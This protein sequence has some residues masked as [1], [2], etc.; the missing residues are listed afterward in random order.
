MSRKQDNELKRRFEHK[1]YLAKE[2]P[3]NL[4]D[5][6]D[7][8]LKEI[9]SGTFSLAKVL[10][11]THLLLQN[12]A[13]R[14]LD[15]GGNL[16]DL[17]HLQVLDL[18]SNL[19]QRL[20]DK[21]HNF[22]S[23]QI[24][25]LSKNRLQSL[26]PSFVK[27]SSL[28][29]L[30]LE[31]NALKFVPSEIGALTQLVVLGLAGNPFSEL[32]DQIL[33][34]ANLQELTLP[35]ERMR[36]P[37]AD[38]C[39]DGV[40]AILRFIEGT[41]TGYNTSTSISES[42][43]HVSHHGPQETGCAQASPDASFEQKPQ[44]Q[45]L[46]AVELER[47]LQ[48]DQKGQMQ[49]A[50][51]ANQSRQKVLGQL[52]EDEARLH[53]ELTA[54]QRKRDQD[55][56]KLVH[57]LLSAE[58][59]ADRLIQQLL[60]RNE[61]A[62]R[63]EAAADLDNLK[64][65]VNRPDSSF[66]L[67]RQ[68]ILDAMQTM[69]SVTDEAY[70]GYT[71]QRQVAQQRTLAGDVSADQEVV[72]L[73]ADRHEKQKKLTS[74]IALEEEAQKAAFAKLQLKQDARA[75]RLQRDIVLI[76]QELCYLTKTEQDRKAKRTE[77]NQQ[78]L[79]QRRADLVRL[80]AQL[81]KEQQTRQEE[82]KARLKEMEQH[83]VD[84]QLDYWLIQY[85]RL[86]DNKPPELSNKLEP[87]VEDILKLAGGMDFASNLQY[88]R[89]TYAVLQTM[90]ED[91]LQ[92]IGVYA[93]GVRRAILGAVVD[94]IQASKLAGIKLSADHTVGRISTP[95]APPL[96]ETHETVPS[97]PSLVLARTANECCI[98][99]DAPCSVVFLQCGHVCTCSACAMRVTICPLCR[100]Y[101]S[102]RIE[103]Q[104]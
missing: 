38:V 101:I 103:L 59:S 99:Q 48:E 30:N 34:L 39:K 8:G 55:H 42:H 51:E 35:V 93:A 12:N 62:K 47:Q 28:Y 89:I 13:L 80:L 61:A 90:T 20:P 95:S 26:P 64:M 14:N 32:P 102:Q 68:E 11:K 23:L 98:C 52:V 88:H 27:L 94:R 36:F 50:F 72:G 85:Q 77:V 16:S 70:R 76:E 84:D 19:L 69:L 57:T 25:N 6:A 60:S 54:V 100:C 4:F 74:E 18:S 56:T 53:A 17:Q 73:L 104:S 33:K 5:L 10:L 3:D 29:K 78:C 21:F 81:S 58:D 91:D 75:Q 96:I 43:S 9:P 7:C 45:R 65:L 86:L 87:E 71:A 15:S 63:Q 31:D 82:L 92:R 44:N 79:N 2:R 22:P 1:M 97:A 40:D 37:P 67:R 66:E 24:L 49:L 41:R 46:R 83:R